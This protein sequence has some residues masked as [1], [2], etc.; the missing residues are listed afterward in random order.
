MHVRHISNTAQ[1]MIGVF[2]LH[3]RWW[4]KLDN[5]LIEKVRRIK[6]VNPPDIKKLTKSSAH[7]CVWTGLGLL[8]TY[9]TIEG[10]SLNH[11]WK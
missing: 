6:L 2:V 1:L 3:R 8:T 4:V 11:Q 5:Y 10:L 7:L 9:F